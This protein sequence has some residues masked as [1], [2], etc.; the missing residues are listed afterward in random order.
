MADELMRKFNAL[1]QNEFDY[2]VLESVDVEIKAETVRV[3]LIYPEPNEQTVRQNSER[4]T[5]AMQKI[6]SGLKMKS[7][8]RVKLTKSHFDYDFFKGKL[9]VF[10]EQY[11][12]VAPYVFAD[13]IIIEKK[14]EY[15]FD[16]KLKIDEDVAQIALSRGMKQEVGKML[17]SSYCEKISFDFLPVKI[18][19]KQDYIE[20]A[21][22]ELKNYVYQTNGGHYI[23]PE[24]VEEFVGKIIYDRAG[25][26]SD[27]K[28]EAAG[29]VYCG[30]VSEFSECVRKPKEGETEERKFYK[31]TITDPT[32]SL[33][34]L[35][36]PRKK[37]GE[38][39][40]VNLRDGKDVVVKGSLKENRFRGQVT[41]DM[42]VNSISLCTLP[43][44]IEV[45]KNE[46]RAASQYKTVKPEKYFEPKQSNMFDVIKPPA[47][48]LKNKTF[49]V[50]DVET[51]G[52]D[53]TTCKIIEVGAV[54]VESGIITQTFSTYVNPCEPISERITQ[55]TSITDADVA[56]APTIADV[57][58][59]FYKF[60]EGTTLVGHNVNFDLG[61]INAE[62]KP[63]G[64]YFDNPREDTLEL[65]QRYVKGLHN[66]KLGTVVKHFGLFNEHAHRAIHDAIA[67]AKV[68][69]KLADFM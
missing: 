31:F 68:F 21:E 63:Y 33:K 7:D 27:A 37:E 38:T 66:Y 4:I 23:I 10:F 61:F 48:W 65:S 46:Y 69:I 20:I 42:F 29:V 24:N 57:L 43:E 59:D 56:S 34:C 58:P 60:T 54:K 39:N 28:R 67:T 19:N 11:P 16:V 30:K 22:N 62:G 53:T 2:L 14:D 6:L 55:L 13:N 18:E 50:F 9:I 47:E 52:F 1:T 17:A 51:T 64:I 12:S 40:I 26:I 44:N 36:F 41:Y 15:E 45:E 25:Y 35:H 8:V 32:G 3:N 5:E 49:C